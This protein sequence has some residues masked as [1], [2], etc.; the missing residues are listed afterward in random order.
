MPKNRKTV[1][2]GNVIKKLKVPSK[3]RVGTRSGGSSA[4]LMSNSILNA[5]L[6]DAD[7]RRDWNKIKGVLD[8]RG[9]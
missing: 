3:F 1:K 9:G 8:A 5:L 7:Y 2:E 6:K 4:M